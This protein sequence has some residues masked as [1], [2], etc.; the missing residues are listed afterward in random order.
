MR[1]KGVM[2]GQSMDVKELISQTRILCHDLNQPLTVIMV[3][4][5]LALMKI[6]PDDPNQKTI[7]QIHEQSERMSII[8]EKIKTLL[9][10]FQAD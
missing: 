9:T 7:E 3:R 2:S 1:N 5:E 4:S 10:D 8:M 6:S